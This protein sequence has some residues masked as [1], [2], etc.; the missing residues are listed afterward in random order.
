LAFAE[1]APPGVPKQFIGYY[2]QVERLLESI[3]LASI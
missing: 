3:N 1:K 2:L